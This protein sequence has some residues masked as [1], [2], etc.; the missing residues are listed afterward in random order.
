MKDKPHLLELMHRSERDMFYQIQNGK[1]FA[2]DFYFWM[3]IN[4]NTKSL[5][6]LL[7]S[8]WNPPKIVDGFNV[9]YN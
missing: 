1:V 2:K 7:K 6:F 4:N 3:N 9:D 8:G 5:K